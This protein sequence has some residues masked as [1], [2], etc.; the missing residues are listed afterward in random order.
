MSRTTRRS[1]RNRKVVNWGE[2]V[3]RLRQIRGS[4][5]QVEFGKALGVHQNVVSRYERGAFRPPIEYL[6]L[7]AR[8]G[9]VTLDWIILGEQ[10]RNRRDES[11][12]A[13]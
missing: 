3:G 5:S 10:P 8:R 6:V 2:I 9:D 13:G 7:M 1:V 12:R 4:T 11:V